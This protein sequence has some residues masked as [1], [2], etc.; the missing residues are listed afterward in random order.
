[1]FDQARINP[2]GYYDNTTGI[3]TIPITGTY[4]FNVHAGSVDEDTYW[5]TS[6]VVDNVAYTLSLFTDDDGGSYDY[7]GTD[8]SLVLELSSGQE[9]WVRPSSMNQ[10]YGSSGNEMYSWFSGR[11]IAPA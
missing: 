1:M 7:I 3:Y 4:E 11:L 6:I 10:M 2:G 9:V 8:S 5:G